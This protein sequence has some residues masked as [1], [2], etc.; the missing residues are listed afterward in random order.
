MLELEAKF[1]T[2]EVENANFHIFIVQNSSSPKKIV[3]TQTTAV[4]TVCLPLISE[5]A[6]SYRC[7]VI[8]TSTLLKESV[9]QKSYFLSQ[10]RKKIAGNLVVLIDLWYCMKVK[11]RE[12]MFCYT[13]KVIC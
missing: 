4:L 1:K 11:A 12:K 9:F 6:W 8:D 3:R 2:Q 5:R 10:F 7:T 13:N